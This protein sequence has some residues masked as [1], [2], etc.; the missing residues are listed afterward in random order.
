MVNLKRDEMVRPIIG[1]GHSMGANNLVALSLMHPR[2]F[3]SLIL[4]DP[5]LQPSTATLYKELG[6]VDKDARP[7]EFSYGITVARLSAVRRDLWPSRKAAAESF[8][9][10][11]FYQAWDERVLDL[12]IE[13]GLRDC[14]TFLYPQEEKESGNPK[15]TLTTSKHLEVH[16]FGRPNL[17][18]S[19]VDGRPIDRVE[20][21]DVNPEQPPIYPL[22]G[23]AMSNVFFKLPEVRPSVQYIFGGTSEMSSPILRKA[24]VEATG[25]GNG[26]SGGAKEGRVKEV[27]FKT[28]SH[29]VAMEVPKRTAEAC[30]DWMKD[31]LKLWK[32]REDDLIESYNKQ[33]LREKRT[34]SK[35]LLDTVDAMTHVKGKSKL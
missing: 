12:W 33:T 27:V 15:V 30:A 32:S 17:S 10:A 25:I 16:T 35:E 4:I 20:T 5:T 23:N 24:K 13:H 28:V 2:L 9:K 19:G 7:T 14:P 8:R 26:G 6:L 34:M 18:K 31:E 21:P 11:K 29:L 3:A 1:I 22:Y